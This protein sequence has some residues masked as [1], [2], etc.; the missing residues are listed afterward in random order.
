MSDVLLRGTLRRLYHNTKSPK[1]R[2]LLSNSIHPSVREKNGDFGIVNCS[3][4]TSKVYSFV[5]PRQ[6]ESRRAD[7]RFEAFAGLPNSNSKI[8][9]RSMQLS[10]P[11]YTGAISKSIILVSQIKVNFPSSVK[12]LARL[13][14]QLAALF[15]CLQ[16]RTH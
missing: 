1:S 16:T 5:F 4:F 11:A 10:L 13:A 12:S 7:C 2:L 15:Q 9:F 14:N 6:V 3:I 8:D